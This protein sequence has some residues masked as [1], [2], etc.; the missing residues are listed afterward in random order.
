[1]RYVRRLNLDDKVQADLDSR[2]NE[3]PFRDLRDKHGVLWAQCANAF[4]EI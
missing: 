2:Q 4:Q 1:M 3:P